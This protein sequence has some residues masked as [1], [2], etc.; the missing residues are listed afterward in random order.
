VLFLVNLLRSGY[1][2]PH[3]LHLQIGHLIDYRGIHLLRLLPEAGGF[4]A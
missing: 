2:L 1:S 4:K 3:P